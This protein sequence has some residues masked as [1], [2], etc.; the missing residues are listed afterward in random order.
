[1]QLGSSIDTPE[2]N[3]LLDRGGTNYVELI[4]SEFNDDS[5]IPCSTMYSFRDADF[6]YSILANLQFLYGRDVPIEILSQVTPPDNWQVT[7]LTTEDGIRSIAIT[8]SG[9]GFTNVLKKAHYQ[10]GEMLTE[11]ACDPTQ[12]NSTLGRREALQIDIATSVA[13]MVTGRNKENTLG[14]VPEGKASDDPEWQEAFDN[15]RSLMGPNDGDP[16]RM[17]A[18]DIR[19]INELNRKKLDRFYA[20][21]PHM[22]PKGVKNFRPSYTLLPE[23]AESGDSCSARD[24]RRNPRSN[25]HVGTQTIFTAADKQGTTPYAVASSSVQGAASAATVPM[26]PRQEALKSY[27]GA[28]TAKM[29]SQTTARRLALNKKRQGVV[30]FI[31]LSGCGEAIVADECQLSVKAVE[32]R[33]RYLLRMHGRVLFG[34]ANASKIPALM[35]KPENMDKYN[36]VIKGMRVNDALAILGPQFGD[37][38][39]AMA[40]NIQAERPVKLQLELLWDGEYV[41]GLDK[42]C[43]SPAAA[44]TAKAHEASQAIVDAAAAAT[45]AAAPAPPPTPDTASAED[46]DATCN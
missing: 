1:M 44:V 41:P 18:A 25:P 7:V 45:A 9:K 2:V 11:F 39:E 27:R 38:L 35:F 29:H 19:W 14:K 43:L 8:E 36:V 15:A 46:G 17:L 6:P 10:S 4:K 24:A 28:F 22:I 31:N 33:L 20:E 23:P 13:D 12:D 34:E 37:D 26:S 42:A 30:L 32:T 5:Q 3:K 16:P 21:N 40:E